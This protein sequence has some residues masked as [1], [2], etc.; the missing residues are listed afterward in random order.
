MELSVL[1]RPAYVYTAGHAVD[2]A[3]ATVVF[4]HGGEQDHSAWAL[5]SRY[6]AHHGYGVL[7]DRPLFVGRN[8]LYLPARYNVDARF[9]RFI[10]L[11]GTRRLEVAAEFKNLFNTVQTSAVNR[12]IPTTQ[13][14]VRAA[15]R[16][17]VPWPVAGP[18]DSSC[19]AGIVASWNQS[20]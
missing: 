15:A 12:I 14:D 17:T 10:P 9:S 5:Q 11:G 3:A 6:F 19:G 18:T 1:G 7:A 4:I 2:P 20:C 13:P 16:S 8:S